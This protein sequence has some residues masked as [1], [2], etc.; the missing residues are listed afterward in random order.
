MELEIKVQPK[1]KRN[2]I[3]V[4]KAGDVTVRVTVAPDKGKANDAVI[5]LL[6]KRLRL[7]KG[8]VEIVQGHR[9][10]NKLVRIADLTRSQLIERLEGN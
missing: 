9:S 1:A 7:P 8:G 3:E 10:R 5:T 6:A 4:S 2:A